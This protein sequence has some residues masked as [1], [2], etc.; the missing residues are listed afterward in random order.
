MHSYLITKYLYFWGSLFGLGIFFFFYRAR[1][2][3]RH[4]MLRMGIAVGIVGVFSEG[5]FFRDYWHPPLIFRLGRYGGIEDLFFGLAFG[6]VCVVIYDVVFHKRLRRKG[7]PHYWIT[8]LLII[9]EV[10]SIGLLVPHINSIY[11]S[12]IGFII[13]ALAIM[14]IRRDLI[15][16]TLLSAVL[17]GSLLAFAEM[18]VL[19]IAPDYLKQY[20]LLYGKA[21]LILGVVPLTEF[22]WGASFAAIV[23]PL[24]DFEFGYVPVSVRKRGQTSIKTKPRKLV[25][26]AGAVRR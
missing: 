6:G 12:A 18:I 2:D 23:G 9:S 1:R 13:P 21:P 17:G 26:A 14:I 11:A 3:L 22:L 25:P 19:L 4:R 16:E 7:Y 15:A 20:Y 24:R 10:V 5:V 8:T